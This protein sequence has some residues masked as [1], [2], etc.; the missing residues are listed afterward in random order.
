MAKLP[1]SFILEHLGKLENV[2]V[3][4]LEFSATTIKQINF[5]VAGLI[6]KSFMTFYNF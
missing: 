1:Q 5:G 3:M 4:I 6:V 2:N